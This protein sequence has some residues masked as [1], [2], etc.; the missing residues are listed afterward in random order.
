MTRNAQLYDRNMRKLSYFHGAIDEK[1]IY[2]TKK[3]SSRHSENFLLFPNE[4]KRVHKKVGLLY[5]KIIISWCFFM[6]EGL[7][8]EEH[9]HNNLRLIKQRI[10]NEL[11]D[12]LELLCRCRFRCEWVWCFWVDKFET[13][14]IFCF[15]AYRFSILCWCVCLPRRH[16]MSCSSL[17]H[18]LNKICSW[19]RKEKF[20][21]QL[22]TDRTEFLP[23]FFD[24]SS[25]KTF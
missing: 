8:R 17:I 11:T 10:R 5:Q 24:F 19:D 1:S 9:N 22:F 4:Y 6:R 16:L 14:L 15:S 18:H 13:F 2:S 20:Y 12:Y 21:F 25:F 7:K 23:S 3:N